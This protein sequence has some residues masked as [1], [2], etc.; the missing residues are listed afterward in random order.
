M[1]GLSGKVLAIEKT[2]PSYTLSGMDEATG[3]IRLSAAMSD[4]LGRAH[5]TFSGTV[6]N[7]LTY[8]WANYE[9]F[10]RLSVRPGQKVLFL[11]MNPGPYGMMQTGVPFG[12]VRMVRDY[13]GITGEI[14]M[15]A[16][17][18]ADKPVVGMK[19][20]KR[21]VSGMKFWGMAASYGSP[22][23]FFSA[24]AVLTYCPLVFIDGKR[25]VTPSELPLPDR[26][27]IDSICLGYLERMLGILRPLKTIALGHYAEERLRKAGVHDPV[28]FPHPSPR[29]PSSSAF[30][31]RGEALA[32]FRRILDEA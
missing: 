15:P 32:S 3:I 11:G 25:N 31:D 14:D 28:Y 5:F 10:V 24:A 1:H 26:K 6:C 23:S 9:A 7:P 4:E 21:E 18:N 16:A 27:I 8:A 13:L 19:T 20:E 2:A 17:Q 12:D 22:D 29:N 30:W